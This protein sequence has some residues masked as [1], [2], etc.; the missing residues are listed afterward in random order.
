MQHDLYLRMRKFEFDYN[1]HWS[2]IIAKCVWKIHMTAH[3][4]LDTTPTQ[5]VFGRD[6]LFDLSFTTNDN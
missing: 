4:D 6:M 2:Q 5:I 1:D 3:I